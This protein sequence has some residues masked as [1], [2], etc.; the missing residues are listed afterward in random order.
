MIGVDL[1][2]GLGNQLF[3]YA[4]ARVAA[5]RLGCSLVVRHA[6]VGP[7]SLLRNIW[8]RRVL[9]D[10][11]AF[12]RVSQAALGIALHAASE[13]IGDASS[14]R[15]RS[16]LFPNVFS[17][18]VLKI[19]GSPYG[20]EIYDSRFREIESGT[21]LRGYFQSPQYFS[22][23]EHDVAH[24]FTPSSECQ[25]AVAALVETFPAPPDRMVA[26]HVRRGDYLAQRDVFSHP[27]TGW[28]LP[29]RYYKQ[30]IEQLPPS[31]KLAVFSDDIHYAQSL[32]G[33]YDPWLPPGNDRLVDLFLM[34]SCRYMI[35]ANSSYSWWAAW[36]NSRSDK[37]VIAPKYHVGW[38]MK[39]WYFRDIRTPGWHY[40]EPNC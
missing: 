38:R 37:I 4:A 40:V 20:N 7:R 23:F 39:T 17:P 31:L 1:A 24:W 32:F 10:V 30:A 29:T 16:Y 9:A 11:G 28:A 12:P 19:E 33:Q 34:A 26:I 36:L 8:Y 35:I 18:T 14:S 6:P 22:G 5:Q 2:G 27:E 15:I 3:Q 13:L 25:A 21:L